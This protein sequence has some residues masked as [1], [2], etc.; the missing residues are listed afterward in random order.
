MMDL[1]DGDGGVHHVGLD[2]LLLDDRLDNLVDVT[3]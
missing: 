3:A 1:V 2:G